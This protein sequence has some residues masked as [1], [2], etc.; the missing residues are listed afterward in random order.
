MRLQVYDLT[1]AAALAAQDCGPRRLM[2]TGEWLWL[3]GEFAATYGIRDS[4]TSL[5]H[6]LWIVRWVS[7]TLKSSTQHPTKFRVAMHT[8]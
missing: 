4:Y 7:F 3:L 8:S 5:A 2:V 1:L 6:L